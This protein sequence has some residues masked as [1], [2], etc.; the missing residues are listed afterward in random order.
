MAPKVCL[1]CDGCNLFSRHEFGAGI[2]G[3]FVR[4]AVEAPVDVGVKND[5]AVAIRMMARP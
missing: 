5:D 3:V 2:V 4:A 1:D